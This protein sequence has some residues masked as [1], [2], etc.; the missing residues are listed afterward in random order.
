MIGALGAVVGCSMGWLAMIIFNLSGGYDISSYT[1]MGEIYALM[2]D[3]FFA[4]INPA[5]IIQQGF[6]IVVMAILA[7]LIPAWQASRKQP[8]DALHH[9]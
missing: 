7:S 1:D 6:I 5:S 3:A 9:I 4:N 2:G 8:A